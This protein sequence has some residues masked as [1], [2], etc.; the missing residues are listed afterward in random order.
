MVFEKSRSGYFSFVHACLNQHGQPRE[1]IE[2]DIDKI[3][4]G[5]GHNVH[6]GRRGWI[7]DVSKDRDEEIREQQLQV[8]RDIHK[9]LVTPMTLHRTGHGRIYTTGK[10]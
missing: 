5:A 2:R 1:P 8:I 4:A 10:G 7:D 9:E 6:R 3:L